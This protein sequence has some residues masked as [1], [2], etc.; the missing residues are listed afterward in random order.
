MPSPP[1]LSFEVTHASVHRAFHA[2]ARRR[3]F[4]AGSCD[5]RLG[6]Y[7]SFDTLCI[8]LESDAP[9]GPDHNFWVKYRIAVLNQKRPDRTVWKDSAICTKQWNNSVLQFMKVCCFA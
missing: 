5:L 6:M 7:E 1:C 3:Y 2:T 4:E 9:A 8:Y